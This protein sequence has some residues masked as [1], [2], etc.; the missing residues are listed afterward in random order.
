MSDQQIQP[1]QHKLGSERGLLEGGAS[2]PDG[3]GP[4]ETRETH[5]VKKGAVSAETLPAWMEE[6]EGKMLEFRG[7]AGR[8][9]GKY[10]AATQLQTY[11]AH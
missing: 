10:G 2:L 9:W 6:D 11:A 8:K 7:S 5:T 3:M 4:C 1:S